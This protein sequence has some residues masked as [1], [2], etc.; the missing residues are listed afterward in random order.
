MHKF[1]NS[2]WNREELPHQWKDSII[3]PFKR[4]AIKL[5]AII[6]VG[7]HCYQLQTKLYPIS[8]PEV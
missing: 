5:T 1:I 7:S 3:V 6:F 4:R 2:I 8:F